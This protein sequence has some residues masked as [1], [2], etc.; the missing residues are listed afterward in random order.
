MY[1]FSSDKAK[2]NKKD[3]TYIPCDDAEWIVDDLR[4]RERPGN[5]NNLLL[6]EVLRRSEAF[7]SG[8]GLL[9]VRILGLFQFCI[10]C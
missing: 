4:A 8:D 10:L 9:P 5:R 7:E 2:Y 6:S 3:L 1:I